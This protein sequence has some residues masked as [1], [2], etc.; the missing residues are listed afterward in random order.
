VV[1][2]LDE[3]QARV[4]RVRDSQRDDERAHG[5]EDALYTDLLR[6]YAANGCPL[7]AEALKPQEITFSRWCA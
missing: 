5:E 1:V 3:V 4:Q 2:T 6:H 7:A